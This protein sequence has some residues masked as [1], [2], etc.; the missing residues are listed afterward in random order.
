MADAV[1][2]TVGLSRLFGGLAALAVFAV[3]RAVDGYGNLG[4]H[5]GD[6][7]WLHWLHVSKY[8]PSLSFTALELGIIK[9]P[10]KPTDFYTDEF[11]PKKP[12]S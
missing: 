7:G 8:P 11:L 3:V 1:L 2:E 10:A 6:G 5:R 4:L 12:G 9:N